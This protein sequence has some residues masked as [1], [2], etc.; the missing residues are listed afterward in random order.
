MKR[1][2]LA[3][4]AAALLL[5]LALVACGGGEDETS[6]PAATT[7]EPEMTDTHS[8]GDTG[9]DD[10]GTTTTA[11]ADLRVT[12]DRLLGEHA[13]LAMFA[14]QKGF[15]GEK[16]FEQIAAA[17]DDNSVDLADA[18]GSVYGDEARAEFLDGELKWRAH[19][20]AF[21]DYTKAL[22]TEDK[23]AQDK[24]V[25]NLMGYVESFGQ[26]LAGATDLPSEAVRDSLTE[27][28]TQLKTQLDLYAKGDYA[29]AYA[30][31]REAYAHMYMTGDTLAGGIAA[32]NEDQFGA[33]VDS[34]ATDLR[35][36]LDRLL[37]EHAI[38]AMTATQKGFS[39]GKDFEAIAGALDANS[40]ELADAIGS[41]YGAD[42][43]KT[44]LDG[45]LM[46]RAHIGFFV[47]YTVGL[48]K[49]DK[50]MQDKA[51]G[52]LQGYQE[53]FSNFLADA[54]GLPQDAVR[55]AITAHVTQLKGQI[56]AYAAG[57]YDKAYELYREAYAHMFMTGDTLAGAIVE[58]SP[59]KFGE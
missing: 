59:E 50:A 9:S 33:G 30:T 32:Q 1:T 34:K 28:V 24:A 29:G 57:D 15:S 7:A 45:D 37:G 17:L 56:D 38:L 42:A 46:W 55:E 13:M 58:Q 5:P 21:V 48:A 12:L 40:V 27:H 39:G 36:T 10:G 11:A 41:V 26:F 3:T 49:K 8:M 31:L 51:V 25:G 6:A 44:F 35:V 14:T 47:D 2:R 52:N 16:D 20:A 18:I 19:I 53:A 54:T 43:R 4:I 22:A 23:A